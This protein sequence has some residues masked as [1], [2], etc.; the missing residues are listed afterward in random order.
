VR[1]STLAGCVFAAALALPAPASATWAGRSARIAYDPIHEIHSV[2]PDGRGDHRVVADAA[3]PDWSRRGGWLLY[4]SEGRLERVRSDGTQRHVVV[5]LDDRFVG[6]IRGG[7]WSPSGKR[8]AFETEDEVPLNEDD[9]KE[10]WR[11][12]VAGRH[13]RHSHRVARGGLS[14][15]WSR[16]G[17]FVY[18]A[19]EDGD[20]VR[21]RPDGKGK[22]IVHDQFDAGWAFGLD[23]APN[24]RRLA[25]VYNSELHR[26]YEV[27]TLNLRTGKQKRAPVALEGSNVVI[28]DAGWTPNGRR[29]VFLRS[30]FEGPGELRTMHPDGSD[31]RTLMQLPA[32]HASTFS[33]RTR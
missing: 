5:A 3:R 28:G 23:L 4:L 6:G 8:V 12:Y 25:Y 17:R 10:V 15:V 20:I 32:S 18:Y 9:F 11:V 14:P 27:R 7:T 1:R 31:Q 24:G 26:D 22:R 19:D 30:S 21:A 13:G 33:W 16:D 2:R 29:V